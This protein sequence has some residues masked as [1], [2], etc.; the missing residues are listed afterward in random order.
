MEAGL[1][2]R[3]TI[4]PSMPSPQRAESELDPATSIDDLWLSAIS[5]NI[6]FQTNTNRERGDNVISTI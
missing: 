3:F 4:V 2:G 1:S 5:I 6:T